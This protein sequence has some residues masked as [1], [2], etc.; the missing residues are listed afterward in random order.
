MLGEYVDP[1]FTKVPPVAAL[2]QFKVPPVQPEPDKL[3]TPGP[4]M[5]ALVTVG[6]AGVGFTVIVK[7]AV[8]PGHTVVPLVFT[9][10]TVIVAV[11][12]VLPGFC[13]TNEGMNGEAIGAEPLA[14]SPIA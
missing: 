12:G 8:F 11:I 6:A 3:T 4:Q 7:D 1:V 10:V 13:A 2:Y 14:T 9:G 5:V